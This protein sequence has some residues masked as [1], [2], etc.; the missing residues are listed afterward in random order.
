MQSVQLPLDQ[1][2]NRQL[3]LHLID[4]LETQAHHNQR[5]EQFMSQ[6]DQSVEGLQTAI[7]DLTVRLASQNAA[8]TQAVSDANAAL[9]VMTAEDVS[10]QAA[11]DQALLDLQA[12]LDNAA[13]ASAAIDGDVTALNAIGA[14]PEVP[15]EPVPVDELPP[16]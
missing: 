12:A 9:A 13:A 8:L 15:V 5:M 10:D 16:A 2:T 3:H 6:L 1:L 11:L 4:L 14:A 7:D